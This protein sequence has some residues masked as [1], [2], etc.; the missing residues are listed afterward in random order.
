MPIY[1]KWIGPM[2]LSAA[3]YKKRSQGGGDLVSNMYDKILYQRDLLGGLEERWIRCD[4]A[5]LVV[6]M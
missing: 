6:G 5:L 2:M 1:H 3:C 4:G